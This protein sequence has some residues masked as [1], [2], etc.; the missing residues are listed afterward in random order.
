SS[1]NTKLKELLGWHRHLAQVWGQT[2]DAHPTVAKL[3]AW[4][5]MGNLLHNELNSLFKYTDPSMIK[6][7]LNIL[8]SHSLNKAKAIHEYEK[9]KAKVI[10]L[11]DLNP[12]MFPED[13]REAIDKWVAPSTRH[14]MVPKWY[15]KLTKASSDN[16]IDQTAPSSLEHDLV[17]QIGR[18]MKRGDKLYKEAMEDH[19]AL[20]WQLDNPDKEREYSQF[21]FD[22]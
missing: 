8:L 13:V 4:R 6:G 19:E 1:Q 22:F 14:S 12:D 20:F 2:H 11:Q 18:H 16:W 5:E 10:E 9:A 21:L 15:G 17:L 3:Y 7:Q